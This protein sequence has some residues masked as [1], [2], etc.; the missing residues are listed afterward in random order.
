MNIVYYLM[1]YNCFEIQESY[2]A[3]NNDNG[4]NVIYGAERVWWMK[5]ELSILTQTRDDWSG[6]VRENSWYCW[7]K[8]WTYMNL[9]ENWEI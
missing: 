8:W 7:W 9:N 5:S 3:F 1:N 6:W 4:S 2:I